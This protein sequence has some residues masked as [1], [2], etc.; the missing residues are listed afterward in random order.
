MTSQFPVIQTG[1]RPAGS[2]KTP[3]SIPARCCRSSA[4]EHSLGKGEVES[5]S[6]SGSTIFKPY[7]S[8]T[9]NNFLVSKSNFFALFHRTVTVERWKRCLPPRLY[10]RGATFYQRAAIPAEIRETCPRAEDTLALKTKDYREAVGRVRVEAA[11]SDR[12][13]AAHRKALERAAEPANVLPSRI[14]VDRAAQPQAKR[15]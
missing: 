2:G 14:K 11:R 6:L 13:F 9:F 12:L 7:I 8:I 15:G 4:V 1:L 5:S 3:I 10:C